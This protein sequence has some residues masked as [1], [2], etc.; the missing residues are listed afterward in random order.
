MRIIYIQYTN[1]AGYPPLEHSS[2]IL[3]EAGWQVLFLGIGALGAGALSFQSHPNIAVKQLSFCAAGLRQKFHYALYSLWVLCWV[4]IWRPTWIYASDPLACP[5]AL[6]LTRFPGLRLVYHEH[7]SP[8]DSSSLFLR[9]TRWARTRVAARAACAVLPNRERA[10]RFGR[11]YPRAT[12]CCVWNCPRRGEV[13]D[14]RTAVDP[15][16]IWL[17]YHGSISSE[18]LPLSMLTA[19]EGLP[20]GLRLRIIGY[21]TVGS[22]GYLDALRD[23]AR[24]LGIGDRVE[25]LGPMPRFELLKYCRR[26]DIGITLMPFSSHDLNMSAMPGASNKAF[27]YLACGLPVLV[28]DLPEWKRMYVEPGYGV[29][30]RPDEPASIVR[31]VDGLL[32]DLGRMRAMGERGRARIASEWNY[33]TEFAKVLTHLSGE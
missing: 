4:L 14:T 12:V 7:D 28:S 24:E 30:C 33:E 10:Q 1:P 27:D 9:A 17:L 21:E 31:A 18:R 6:L 15:Q 25:I 23:R 19:V 26:S 22:K 16:H 11:E 3:A 32:H 20:G 29:A 2:R 8:G 5:V 13:S